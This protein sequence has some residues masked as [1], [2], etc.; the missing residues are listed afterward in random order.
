MKWLSIISINQIVV[1][2]ASE[3]LN[4][5]DKKNNPSKPF[6]LMQRFSY[7]NEHLAIRNKISC[8]QTCKTLMP[9]HIWSNDLVRTMFVWSHKS[10]WRS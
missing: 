9:Y 2:H 1:I 10:I 7:H 6:L 5:E 4:I 8:K 3:W